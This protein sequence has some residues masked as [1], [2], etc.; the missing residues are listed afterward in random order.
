MLSHHAV[1]VAVALLCGAAQAQGFYLDPLTADQAVPYPTDVAVRPDGGY[2]VLDKR[3]LVFGVEPDGTARPE[4]V[5][6]L[7]A[8]V[9]SS[10]DRGLLGIALHPDFPARPDVYLYYTAVDPTTVDREAPYGIGRLTRYTVSG[11]GLWRADPASRAVLL[12]TD[13]AD[14]LPVCLPYHAGGTVAFA[15]DGSLLLSWGDAGH[16]GFTDVGGS[17]P[18]CFAPGR[19]DPADDVGAFRAQRLDSPNG[20]IVRVDPETGRGLPDNP[21]WTGDPDATASKVWALG[22][23]NPFRFA[24]DPSA[25]RLR[26]VIGDVGL[27]GWE[28]LDVAEG[29]ENFGWPCYEGPDLLAAFA[30]A[31]PAGVDCVGPWTGA[32]TLPP[33][34]WNHYDPDRSAP[35]GATANSITGGDFY[36][37][38]AYPDAYR[39][40]YVFADF[41]VGWLM[42]GRFAEGRMEGAE[43]IADDIAGVVDVAMDPGQDALLLIDI[44]RGRLV[45]LRHA[46]GG[47]APPVARATA[48]VRTG[49]APFEAQFRG[50]ESLDPSGGAL[51]YD[52]RFGDGGASTEADPV[53]VYQAPGAY[54]AT[55]TVTTADGRPSQATVPVFVGRAAPTLTVVEPTARLV[56]GDE[57]VPLHAEV[58]D[59]FEPDDALSVE[60]EVRLVHNIHEH[61]GF[62][63]ADGVRASFVALGHGDDGEVAFY[64]ATVRVT[65]GEGITVERSV[66]L[67]LAPAGAV[68]GSFTPSWAEGEARFARPLR[69]RSVLLPGLDAVPDSVSVEAWVDGGWVPVVYPRTV[70]EPDGVRVLFVA[71]EAEGVRV[72]P[73][74]LAPRLRL[75]LGTAVGAPEGTRATR[76]GEGPEPD[77]AEA[78]DGALVLSGSA[79]V[80]AEDAVPFVQ[81]LLAEGGAVSTVLDAVVGGTAGLAVRGSMDSDA[82]SAM[83]LANA[84]GALVLHVRDAAGVRTDSLGAV[85]LPARLR[86]YAGPVGLEVA[87]AAPDGPWETRA[88]LLDWP[89]AGQLAGLVLG[90]DGVA[91]AR[92]LRLDAEDEIDTPEPGTLALAP[93]APNPSAG[94]VRLVIEAGREGAHA[95]D[96]LDVLGRR[97]AE[98]TVVADRLGAVAVRLDLGGESAGVYVVRVRHVASGA[99]VT[100]TLTLAR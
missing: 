16:A 82:P 56:R 49:G 28:E 94:R 84:T 15:P 46:G 93:P 44:Y 4:L 65:D 97:V 25:D 9:V 91:W 55:L 50:A 38:A 2:Y 59:P 47:P 18:D 83:L 63:R 72:S 20:K 77:L 37:G 89:R 3:G 21:F 40:A 22:L 5:L 51:A 86:L 14:G 41:S 31:A 60:W 88:H 98:T 30:D 17:E 11:P 39:G 36:T 96:V 27:A 74:G 48:D 90:A 69:V 13:Y 70:V 24:V 43:R 26:L 35:A 6:D 42:A 8:E 85:A 1:L 62:F 61:P 71:V 34:V 76:V 80:G 81:G 99:A 58:S 66:A 79:S 67:P 33:A 95:V 68:V 10:G 57:L 75:G 87:V 64:Q 7:A 92:D 23:R 100:R 29:G 32:F 19:A 12:G 52:W 73:D 45:H 78:A 53:H 54:V